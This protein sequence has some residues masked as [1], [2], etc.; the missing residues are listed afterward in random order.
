MSS[1]ILIA[2]DEKNMRWAL[3]RA[4][5]KEGYDI[6]TAEDGKTALDKFK[7]YEPDLVLMDIRMPE[8][9]GIE[10]LREI[11]RINDSAQVII[12]TAHGTLENAIEAL[13]LGALDY[14]TKPFDIEEVKITIAKAINI[15]KLNSEVRFLRDEIVKG[16]R[17]YK[18]IGKSKNFQ[19]VLDLVARA[20][21]TNANV[22]L[23]G[24]SGTGKELI[25]R[26]VHL[27]S[28]RGDKPYI[29]VNCGA[30]PENL[31]ESELFGHEK[32]AFTGAV[33]RKPGRFERA[34]GGTIFLDEVGELNLSTQVKLLRVIQEKE[35]ERVGSTD[36]IKCDVRII[37]ATNRN[38]EKM[39]EE[40]TF[41]EDLYYRLKVIP[42]M[43]PPLRERKDDIPLLV[44]YFS[45]RFSQEMGTRQIKFSVEAMEYITNYWWPGNIRELENIIERLTILNEGEIIEE[46]MLPRE[47]VE[48]ARVL[49]KGSI[50][51]P[52]DGIVLN[53]VEKNLIVEALQKAGGNKSQAARLLGISRYTLLYRMDK[54]NIK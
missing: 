43:L 31:L 18:I 40:G 53:D 14:I 30:I 50:S 27:N 44:E 20:A 52:Q 6:L 34:D 17:D 26:A 24:E 13:R 51:I 16:G 15:N 32:G 21:P 9:N 10:A 1:R 28:K 3:E 8:L 33:A 7:Q 11:K 37:A 48:N 39:V 19:E 36:T 5:K 4:L 12:M 38:L 46:D 2:D 54:Y 42:I 25:A 47:I 45:K 23:L 29:A 35:F 41:R 22:L 49:N